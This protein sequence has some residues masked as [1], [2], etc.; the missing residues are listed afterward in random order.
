MEDGADE[1]VKEMGEVEW[2]FKVVRTCPMS[3]R[4]KYGGAHHSDVDLG[5][6]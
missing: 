4:R 1:E 6:F 3:L 5:Y 2:M